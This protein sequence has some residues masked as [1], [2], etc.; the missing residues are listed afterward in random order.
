MKHEKRKGPEDRK[1]QNTSG[2]LDRDTYFLAKEWLMKIYK[3]PGRIL[4]HRRSGK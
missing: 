3:Q 2:F 1:A 4:K